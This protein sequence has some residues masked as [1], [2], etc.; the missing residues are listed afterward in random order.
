MLMLGSSTDIPGAVT[1]GT[2]AG[3]LY[4]AR[5]VA[6][7]AVPGGE[8]HGAYSPCA[9]RPLSALAAACPAVT[10]AAP[11]AMP[12]AEASTPGWV[13]RRSARAGTPSIVAANLAGTIP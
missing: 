7:R 13:S 3:S 4:D 2:G 6:G 12:A 9:S 11:L 5:G 8:R 1:R 10:R